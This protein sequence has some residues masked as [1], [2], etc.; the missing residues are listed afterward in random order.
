MVQNYPLTLCFSRKTLLRRNSPKECLSAVRSRGGWQKSGWKTDWKLCGTDAQDLFWCNKTCSFCNHFGDAS[1]MTWKGNWRTRTWI[2]SL[3]PG[4]WPS[5]LQGLD[6]VIAIS[7]PALF[8]LYGMV[9]GKQP[10]T[11][12]KREESSVAQLLEWVLETWKSICS[13][14]VVK[15]VKKCCVTRHGR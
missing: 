15:G 2:W 8:P 13:E 7:G 1:L 12:S 6:I 3:C 14:L 10:C 4:A 11:C 9:T 5:Q